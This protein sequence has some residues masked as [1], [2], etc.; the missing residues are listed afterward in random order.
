MI[1]GC[2]N[3][4]EPL[5]AGLIGSIEGPARVHQIDIGLLDFGLSD[6]CR[7]EYVRRGIAVVTPEWDFDPSL[8]GTPPADY[9][10]AM[11]TRPHLRKYFPGYDCYMWMDADTWVQDWSGVQLYLTSAEAFGFAA[12]P[13][14]DRS[15]MPI[16]SSK[17]AVIAWRRECFLRCFDENV[18]N[19]LALYPTINSGAFAATADAPIW[20]IWSRILG[21]I[22][23]AKHES[24]FFAEQTALNAAIRLNGLRTAF[25]PSTCNWMCNRALPM[26]SEDAVELKEPNPPFQR[27]SVIHLTGNTKNGVW[28]LSTATGVTRTRSLRFR[29]HDDTQIGSDVALPQVVAS[30]QL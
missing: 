2:E 27:I 18:A 22:F 21:Q 7:S 8:F 13:E 4:Y 6:E 15:Y 10:K 9:F 3:R 12:T 17:M 1:T 16:Y 11:T 5:L 23:K 19:K 20:D 25:L 28:P 14:V 30:P 29:G 26:C 24:F